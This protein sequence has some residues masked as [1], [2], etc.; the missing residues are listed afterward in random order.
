LNSRALAAIGLGFAFLGF[1]AFPTFAAG[2]A[3]LVG[4]QVCAR[5]AA[6][7]IVADPEELRSDNGVLKLELTYRNFKT[8]DGRAQYC[9]QYKDG[10]EAPTLRLQPGD[11]L[12]LRLKNALTGLPSTG[13]AEMA[14]MPVGSACANAEMSA[15]STNLHFHGTT[16]PSVCHEDDVLHTAIQPGDPPFEYRFRIRRMS[17]RGCIG[18]THM[19]TASRMRRCLAG[20]REP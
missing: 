11:L 6:G 2:R 4:Q 20:R 10:S 3:K 5:P 1:A 19:Y 16:V 7:S 14:V 18:I 13:V 12:I 9:Y 8:A 17:R 15:L